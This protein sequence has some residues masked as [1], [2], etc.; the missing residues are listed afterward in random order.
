MKDVRFGIVGTSWW[1]DLMH[2]AAIKSHPAASLVA[3]CGRDPERTKAF[4][5][6]HAAQQWFVDPYDMIDRAQFD[7]IVI[8]TPEYA[9]HEICLA[10]AAAG[11]H[12]VCEKPL[13]MNLAEAE[14]MLSA[15]EEVG[16][17]HLTYFTWRWAPMMRYVKQLVVQ[18]YLGGIYEGRFSFLAGFGRDG[19]AH[20]KYDRRTGLGALGDL[21]SHMIDAA[22]WLI[23]PIEEVD[24]NLAAFVDRSGSSWSP[25]DA[26]NDSAYLRVRFA[27]GSH[28]VVEASHVA[29]LGERQMEFEVFLRGAEGTLRVGFDFVHGWSLWGARGDEPGGPLDLPASFTAGIDDDVENPMLEAFVKQNIGVRMFVDALLDDQDVV[30]S[31][32]DGVEVQRVM[33]AALESSRTKARVRI[34]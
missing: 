19:R 2:V 10:A 5:E 14:A 21:G 11:L 25:G 8:A 12:V 18:G 9:H 23:G 32:A 3:C 33:E 4:A 24:A 7:A 31:L 17:K 30:P 28:G 34:A 1:A 16:V 6:K 15:V 26:A 22:L 29:H 27:S 13:G 20:W